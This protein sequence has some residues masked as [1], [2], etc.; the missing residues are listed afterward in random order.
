[1]AGKDKITQYM[2]DHA[3]AYGGMLRKRRAGRVC[4]RPLTTWGSI[5]MVL[6]STQAVGKWDF[7]LHRREIL[8]ITRKFARKYGV[9]IKSLANVGNHIHL[10]LRLTKEAHYKPFIRALTAAIAMAVTKASRVKPLRKEF[11]DYRPFTRL[12]H[13]LSDYLNVYHYVAGNKLEGR[14]YGRKKAKELVAQNA[15]RRHF[16]N[17]AWAKA[18]YG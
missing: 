7:R 14:G 11:W 1:M 12:V 16:W 6:R 5:H 4:A 10:H 8:E 15:R 3:L 18:R 2:N 17:L 13:G 9:K